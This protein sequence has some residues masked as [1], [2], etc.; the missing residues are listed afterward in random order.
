MKARLEGV[1]NIKFRGEKGR[2]AHEFIIN[3]SEFKQHG[4]VEE[5]IAKR[6]I[7]YG[8]HGPT[9]SWPISGGLMIEPTES[10]DINE[11]D[12]LCDALLQIREEI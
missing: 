1:Y 8:F 5:D 2:C 12:R 4:I 7:D 10:E 6:L 3:V 11:C 9:M